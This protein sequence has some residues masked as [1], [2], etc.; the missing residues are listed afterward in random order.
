MLH[1]SWFHSTLNLRV[2]VT[3]DSALQ[4]PSTLTKQ[5]RQVLQIITGCD[6]E[7]ANEVFRGAF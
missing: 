1:R 7:L 3:P 4:L 6:T 5:I 2:Q